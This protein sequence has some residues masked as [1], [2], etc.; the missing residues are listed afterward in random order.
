MT[1]PACTLDWI[2]D[3]LVSQEIVEQ[4]KAKMIS[5][6]VSASDRKNLHPLEIIAN[7]QWNNQ[8]KPEQV[9]TLEVLTDWL[10]EQ[11]GM[12]TRN[13]ARIYTRQMGMTPAKAVEAMR[14]DKARDLLETT[15]LSVKQIA[16]KCGFN[17]E[18]RLRR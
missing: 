6:L 15:S 8:S 18:E 16:T 9:L 3:Q 12:S 5:S 14:T 10:A 1:K 13:F 17:D 4:D 11:A 7:R 2:L